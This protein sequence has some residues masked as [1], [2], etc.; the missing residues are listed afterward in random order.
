MT[1]RTFHISRGHVHRAGAALL[2]TVLVGL[3]LS[4][5]TPRFYP[6]DP[7]S[8]EPDPGDA[9]RVQP[10]PVHMPWDILSSLFGHEGDPDRGPARN[11]NTIDEVPDSSWF[12]NRI[13]S[14]PM[15]EADVGRGPDTT[16]G[17]A[18]R[19]TVVAGKSGGVRP[20]FTIVDAAGIRWFVK[21][22]APDFPEQATGAEV[23][24]TKL[25]W[26]LGYHVAETHVATLR[27]ADLAVSPGATVTIGGRKRRFTAA[28][29]ER[30]LALV[31]RNADGTYRAIASKA[32]EGRPVGEFLYYGTRAD[33][34]NDVVPHEDRRELRGMRVFAAW[35]DRKDAK[36]GNTL[37]T[38][39]TVDGHTVVRH[40]LLDFGSSLGAAEVR[41]SEPW[42]SH[43]YLYEGRPL[44]GKLV[45]AGLPVEGWRTIL[46][47]RLRG[48]GHFEADRFDPD[49][50]KTLWPNAAYLRAGPDD[51]FWAARKLMAV[52][53]GMIAA[54]VEAGHYSDPAARAYLTRTL[55]RRRDVIGR[56]YLARITPVVDP[57]LNDAGLLTFHD[58]AVERGGAAAPDAYHAR[59]WRFDN[60]TGVSTPLGDSSDARVT[61]LQAPS[62]LP[63]DHDA[64]VRVDVSARSSAFPAWAAPV[65]LYFRRGATAWSLVGVERLKD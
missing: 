44:L 2:V 38:L 26:T 50:W 51:T 54:A 34:P 13:G 41:P 37:D 23:V 43:A 33:D 31:H 12:T 4:A 61:A 15:T 16:N 8:R 40:Y 59:W 32:I 53:D 1:A 17:P 52:T 10:F 19:W 45:G 56:T 28:D 62:A 21:F 65:R 55:I 63:R 46:Y 60:T 49:T 58:A 3:R 20:G 35:I 36:P 30:A 47:P 22:D 25:F 7:I 27:R 39:V 48:V 64:L 29:V 14:R 6:D 42:M 11:T 18:G 57:T 9:S 5:A 24:A